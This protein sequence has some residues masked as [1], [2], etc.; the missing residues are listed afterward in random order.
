MWRIS[1]VLVLLVLL[2]NAGTV[3]AEEAELIRPIDLHIP[4]PAKS[5]PFT[6]EADLVHGG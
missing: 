4:A 2:A 5:T 1:R 3:R 6:L